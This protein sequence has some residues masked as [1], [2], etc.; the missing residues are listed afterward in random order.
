MQIAVLLTCY[1]RRET[2]LACLTSLY[3]Q[4]L[5]QKIVFEVYLVDD[6]SIDGTKD[7][8]QKQFPEINIIKGNGSLYWCGG[9][10]L[11]WDE[12][13]KKDYDAYLWL[14]DD[15]V[16]YNNAIDTLI[17]TAYQT[18]RN[19]SFES[20]IV[21]SLQDPN[22]GE[23]TYGGRLLKN[24]DLIIPKDCPLRCER[25]NGNLVLIPKS[26]F[27]RIGNL[28]P[29]F[30]H[31]SGDND[32]GLRAIKEGFKIWMA[33]GYQGC[34]PRNTDQDL[35]ADHNVPLLKRLKILH[36]PK[37]QPFYE[38]YIYAKRHNGL[39]WPLALMKLYLR[40]L[41]PRLYNLVKTVYAKFFR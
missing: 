33:P 9:M 5:P 31:T 2:T 23:S 22:N 3:Q 28:S 6:G 16:L 38:Q 36:S 19:K 37:G 13:A 27:K 32:Y 35:W 24:P 12:A 17:S 8:V 4:I 21:G 30:A 40:V 41:F 20:I 7:T 26:I 25:I 10:R 29:E 11:A 18:K 1:N 39:L 14:N 15:T 34:C